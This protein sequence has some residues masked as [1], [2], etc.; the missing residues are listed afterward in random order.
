M[1]VQIKDYAAL[2]DQASRILRPRG[3]IDIME[4]DFRVY[5]YDRKP[6]E[7]D[8]TTMEAPWFPRWM[9]F[10]RMAVQQLGG[11][12]DAANHLDRW[13]GTHGAFEDTVYREFFI[14]TAPW[15]CG[16]SDRRAEAKRE[17]GVYMR[18]D[19]KVRCYLRSAPI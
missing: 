6:I 8:T 10:L 14:Q 11:D 3:M 13:I 18:A 16:N 9:R 17:Q 12:V 2:I 15:T 5:G 7:V 4:F 19:I 1:A